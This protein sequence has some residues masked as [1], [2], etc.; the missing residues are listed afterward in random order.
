LPSA[1]VAVFVIVVVIILLPTA[2]RPP[3][4]QPLNFNNYFD[5]DFDDDNTLPMSTTDW[6]D[7][8]HH[9]HKLIVDYWLMLL[10]PP[11]SLLASLASRGKSKYM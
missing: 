10:S 8:R 11:P 1:V 6:N 4:P 7:H 9:C 5:N 3:P 2:H